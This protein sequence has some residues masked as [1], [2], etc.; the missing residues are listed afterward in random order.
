LYDHLAEL[1]LEAI[2]AQTSARQA[3]AGLWQ[4]VIPQLP[5]AAGGGP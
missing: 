3:Q 1:R 5:P 2:G 4:Q